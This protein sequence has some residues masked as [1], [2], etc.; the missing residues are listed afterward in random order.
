MWV[1]H[2]AGDYFVGSPSDA[3]IRWCDADELSSA[4][5]SDSVRDDL[6][7]ALADSTLE[8]RLQFNENETNSDGIADMVRF[9]TMKIKVT[10]TEP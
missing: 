3:A 5:L 2:S 8:Y 1:S 10:Y 7:S 4:F 9:S 6:Q